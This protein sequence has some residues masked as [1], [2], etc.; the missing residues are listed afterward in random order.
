MQPRLISSTSRRHLEPTVGKGETPDPQIG[1]YPQLEGHSNQERAPK[2]WWDNQYRRNF[3]EPLHEQDEALNMFSP[4]LPHTNIEPRQALAQA[5]LAFAGFA[6][7]MT[8]LAY[9]RPE[10][11]AA[12]R[13]YPRDGLDGELGGVG[14][15]KARTESLEDS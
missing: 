5:S 7:I 8:F 9:T 4:D 1:T 6:A 13:T 2:G 10:A 11:P 15:N 3:G 12:R 14:V